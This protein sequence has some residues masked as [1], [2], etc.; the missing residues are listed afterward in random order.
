MS[1]HPDL[2]LYCQHSLGLGHLK[3]TW[4]L[5]GALAGAFRVVLLSGGAEPR[6]LCPPHGI[7]IVQLPALEQDE[8]GRL[9]PVDSS[10][11]IDEIQRARTRLILN[12]YRALWPAAVVLELFP[13]GRRKFAGELISM[14]AQTRHSSPPIVASSVRDL[15]VDRGPEQ[16]RHDERARILL[17]QYFDAVFVHS[18]PRFSTLDETFRPSTPLR[19]PVFHTGFVVEPPSAVPRLASSRV[20]VSG[21]GGRFAERLYL[22]AIAAH[23]LLRSAAPPMTIVA[24]P[25]CGDDVLNRL[26][27]AADMRPG[28]RIARTVDDLASEMRASALS[29]SQCG[30]NTALDIVRSGAP[31][32]VV[33]F[34]GNG[35]G[36]Q[37]DRAARLERLGAV[38]VLPPDRL[39]PETLAAA[40]EA[41]R[42]FVPTRVSLDTDGAACTAR[43]LDG[44]VR[45]SPVATVHGAAVIA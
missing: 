21:G 24:G 22:A 41:T 42:R 35:D 25:L 39:S 36:E 28:I 26:C 38:R 12:T 43:L 16:Q 20:L 27:R 34:A 18:D 40:I 3:R 8:T 4:T 44:M 37:S 11:S 45:R 30:Y 10:R 33:P 19:T 9:R 17:E 6:G 15:L 23:E 1:T 5:A 31:A 7:D 14:L 29:V 13:F 2:L 32:L